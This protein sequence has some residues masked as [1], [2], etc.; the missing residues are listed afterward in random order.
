MRIFYNRCIKQLIA[1]FSKIVPYGM[2]ALWP[3]KGKGWA[4]EGGACCGKMLRRVGKGYYDTTSL[5]TCV[6]GKM[7]LGI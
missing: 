3:G 6:L 1:L 5:S 7:F 2:A 4:G